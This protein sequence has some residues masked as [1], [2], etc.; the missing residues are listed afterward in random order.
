VLRAA[1]EARPGRLVHGPT[2]LTAVY[3]HYCRAIII[4]STTPLH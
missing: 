2:S 1:S 3:S 4:M